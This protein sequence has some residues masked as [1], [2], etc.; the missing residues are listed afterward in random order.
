MPGV[1]TL[2]RD[3]RSVLVPI[4]WRRYLDAVRRCDDGAYEVIEELAWSHLLDQLTHIQSIS[5]YGEHRA[6]AGRPH[7]A[8]D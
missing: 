1:T 2:A 7:T 4:A 6:Q 3:T 5:R 8:L